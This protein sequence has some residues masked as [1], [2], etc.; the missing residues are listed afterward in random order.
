MTGKLFW[1]PI[2]M[3]NK[4]FK[5]MLDKIAQANAFEAAFGDRGQT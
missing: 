4:E 3:D 2:D 5:A 1:R